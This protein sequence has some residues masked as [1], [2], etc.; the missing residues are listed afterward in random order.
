MTDLKTL[1]TS[2]AFYM[3]CKH[4]DEA[5][6]ER[7]KKSRTKTLCETLS[8][9]FGLSMGPA[10]FRAALSE[11]PTYHDV[12]RG[13][14]SGYYELACDIPNPK[15]DRRSTDRYMDGIEVFKAGTRFT[16]ESYP[17]KEGEPFH[18]PWV[19]LW[20]SG[21]QFNRVDGP[22]LL[23]LVLANARAVKPSN[24]REVMRT[25]SLSEHHMREVVMQLI[26]AG[27]VTLD[28]VRKLAGHTHR[29]YKEA[30]DEK[31]GEAAQDA[32][33]APH[34]WGEGAP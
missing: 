11:Q 17:Q 5:E 29:L 23:Y 3:G 8:V 27:L 26:D 2:P 21:V 22:D 31:A 10:V 28:E 32:F 19:R 14:E 25:D 34:G 12:V 16:V 9:E 18:F 13:A 24:L 30:V 20:V 4:I 7:A 33:A 1:S 6:T 15:L